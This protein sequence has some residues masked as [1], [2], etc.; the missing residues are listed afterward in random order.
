MF[1]VQCSPPS[2]TKFIITMDVRSKIS[3]TFFLDMHPDL[4]EGI[5]C[6]F[7]VYELSDGTVTDPM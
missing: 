3:I 2:K 5:H 4:I 7:I 1:N 6:H